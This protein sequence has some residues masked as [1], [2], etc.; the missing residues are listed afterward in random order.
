[1]SYINSDDLELATGYLFLSMA[2]VVIN[3]D[4]KHVRE[5]PFKIKEPYVEI[6]GKMLAQATAERRI[7]R[8]KM[9]ARKVQV[10]LLKKDDLFS[11]FL[12][13][14]NRREEKRNYFNPV[15]KKYVKGKIRN[16]LR[17]IA[18]DYSTHF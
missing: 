5:G 9:E 11:T 7:L 14:S 18:Q 13:V 4:L 8:R 6:L 3:Q 10:I 1:M 15:I 2:I 16:L 17:E 12:F